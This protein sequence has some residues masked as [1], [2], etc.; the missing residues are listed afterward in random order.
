MAQLKTVSSGLRLGQQYLSAARVVVPARSIWY[1][2]DNKGLH[3]RRQRGKI[4]INWRDVNFNPAKIPSA[5]KPKD[6]DEKNRIDYDREEKLAQYI[7]G[8]KPKVAPH[9]RADYHAEEAYVSASD[10]SLVYGLSQVASMTKTSLA[11]QQLPASIMKMANDL[12]SAQEQEQ[13]VI[14][15]MQRAHLF[16]I[17]PTVINLKKKF[18]F[19]DNRLIYS[20]PARICN[21]ISSEFQRLSNIRAI[22]MGVNETVRR[23]N[24]EHSPVTASFQRGNLLSDSISMMGLSDSWKIQLRC[25]PALQSIRQKAL[26]CFADAD[27]VEASKQAE[28]MD[29]Y[30][31]LPISDL[32]KTNNYTFTSPTGVRSSSAF[33]NLHTVIEYNVDQLTPEQF[34]G[35]MIKSLFSCLYGRATQ[36]GESSGDLSSPLAGQCI[37]LD[38]KNFHFMCYQLNTTDFETDQGVKNMVWVSEPVPLF[39]ECSQTHWQ[40]PEYYSGFDPKAFK[41]F[42]AMWLADSAAAQSS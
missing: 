15:I 19:Q 34:H 35:K 38:G 31:A 1:K 2:P 4:P 7:P 21:L 6:Y 23:I 18:H 16:D 39:E 41:L 33:S 5:W 14:E 37:G 36:N 22:Q 8:Y 26:S 42:Q 24:I 9:K 25:C 13:N 12:W 40:N 30:P 27:E 29:I 20:S 32:S 11:G 17:D 3:K 10:H 28:V